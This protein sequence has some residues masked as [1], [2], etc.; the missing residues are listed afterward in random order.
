M[1][2]V[3]VGDVIAIIPQRRREKGHQP[4]GIDAQLLK[5][6]KLLRQALEV[7]DPVPVAILKS[8]NVHLIDDR[9]FVPEGI[10][11][12]RQTTILPIS[13]T[14][15]KEADSQVYRNRAPSNIDR[16]ANLSRRQT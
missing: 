13:R 14:S 2:R 1:N 11:I 12:Q 16:R 7:T 6:I 8:A 10:I 3:V 4:Y 5:V 9:V 15:V